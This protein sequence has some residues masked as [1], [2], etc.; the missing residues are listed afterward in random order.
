MSQRPFR[1]ACQAYKA[2]S[3]K[4]WVELARRVEAQGFSAL[5]VADHYIGPGAA[6]EPTGHG[7]Q[8]LAAIPAMAVAA[9]VTTTLRVGSRLFCVGYHQPVVLAKEAATLDLLSEG[10]LE[11]GLGAGWLDREYA[12]MGIPFPSAPD[13]IELLS[14]TV[15]LISQCFAC[16]PVELAGRQVR[17]SG[18]T[19]VPAPVQSPRPPIMIGG[20]G[21]R[22][23]TLAG[24][25]ADIV[26]INFNNASGTVGAASARSST[27]EQTAAKIDWIR[28]GAG[29]R[30]E[31]LEL[32]IGAYFV[33]I[34]GS[35]GLTAMDLGNRLQLTPEQLAE[36]PHALVGSVEEI[37][38]TLQRRREEYGISYITVGDAVADSFAPIVERLAG[39]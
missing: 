30:F 36:F 7:V 38:E 29:D 25:K 3:R 39:Q 21:R 6:L 23:L 17:A 26:S 5:H 24:Q 20:G 27:A 14:E 8:T 35:S 19:A 33:A 28:A 11:L 18:F 1:F 12:A 37:C 15:D 13:R 2:T 34:H 4:E 22:V 10:R 9:E 32:E 16:G 31:Q